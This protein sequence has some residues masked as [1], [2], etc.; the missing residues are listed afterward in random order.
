ML[1]GVDPAAKPNFGWRLG[2]TPAHRAIEF[3]I[4]ASEYMAVR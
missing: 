1:A 3:G 4:L 2:G